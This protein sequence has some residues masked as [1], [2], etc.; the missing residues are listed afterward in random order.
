MAISLSSLQKTKH[1]NPPRI[2]VYGGHGIGKSTFAANAT[3]PVFI[4][5]EDGLD[6]LDATAFPLAKSFADVIEALGSLYTEEHEYK[7]VVI[8]SLDWLEQLIWKKVA[9]DNGK[10]S[11]EDFGYGKGYVFS[12]DHWNTLLAGLNALRE[13]GMITVL[14]AHAEIKRFD[15]PE[16]DP[17]D[18]YQIKLHRQAGAKVQEWAD[19]IGFCNYKLMT[20]NA[21][22]GFDKKVTR[23]VTTGERLMYLEETPAYVAKNRYGLP[24]S[25][26]LTWAS[27][28]EALSNSTGQQAAA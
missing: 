14:T 19:I 27:L 15:S 21:D 23:G 8:D 20:T 5:T 13:K 18:R 28:I 4:Q 6:G 24:S 2:V 17:F 11:I 25:V 16:T 9:A 26:P 10:A 7:T 1:N 12:M 3:A 22:A